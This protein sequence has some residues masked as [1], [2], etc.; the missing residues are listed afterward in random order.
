MAF[1]KI[2]SLQPTL[3][4]AHHITVEADL[5]KG[6]HAFTIVGLADKAVE[7]SRD[8]ISAAIKNSGWKSPK[9]RNQKITI[10]LAPADLKKVGTLFDLPI[11]LCYL[12][13]TKD[14]SFHP[15]EK[16]FVGELALDGA[17]RGIHGAL[18]IA[19]EA[20]KR[21]VKELYV[22]KE[23]AEEAALVS[24]LTIFP[25]VSL[26]ELVQ[27]LSDTTMIQKGADEDRIGITLKRI[28]PQPL[29]ELTHPN[30]KT[31]DRSF[32]DIRG[33]ETAK[34]GLMIAAAGGHNIAMWGPPGTGKTM[35]A[36]AFTELL[37]PLSQREALEVTAIHSVSGV[38]GSGV[39]SAPP[40][41][42]P[43]HT[44]SYVSIIGGGTTPKPGE[45]TLA[46]HG[47]LFLDE[48]P[49]FDKRV[50]ESL[51]QPLEEGIVHISRAKGSERFPAR[52]ILVAA[53]NPCPCGYWGDQKKACVCNPAEISRYQR[54][55]SG[56]I[57]DRIDLWIEVPRLPH[58]TLAPGKRDKNAQKQFDEF[59][60]KISSAR[61]HQEKRFAENTHV[62]LNSTMGVRDIDRMVKLT[63]G[64][65]TLLNESAKR[66]D[67]SP[68][69]YHR[70]IKLA[71]TIADLDESRYV[72]D[73]HILEALQYRPKRLF[74]A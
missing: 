56:P 29:T 5:A 9:Q 44:A 27:H 51:R 54:K 23:N 4:G 72:N 67:L 74:A 73:S 21:G 69:A 30:I 34:R 20:K 48:F 14:I 65:A 37:P 38:L 45:V 52:F 19:T 22:P 64:V 60:K 28:E 16:V 46:H 40:F 32:A 35:L 61:A 49:E 43:H 53:M 57:I 26:Y 47:V 59:T 24:G 1:A 18:A 63:D 3:L 2:F 6:L 68:R 11:A 17:V 50:L 33:Q 55:I 41:R 39:I 8:R 12:L 25:V 13:A 31:T 66:L 42:S 36:R 62:K 70:I 7:E 58:T 71:R 15:E 10:G